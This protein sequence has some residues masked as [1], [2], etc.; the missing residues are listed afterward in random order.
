MAMAFITEKAQLKSG[1]IIF[2]RGVVAHH[3]F[4]CRIMLPKGDRY[5][6]VT[7]GTADRQSAHDQAFG[8]QR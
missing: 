6:T 3:N 1:L 8:C 5:K 7:P 2:R 4:Y